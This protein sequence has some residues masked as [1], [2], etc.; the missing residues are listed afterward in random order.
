M[1]AMKKAI[2]IVSHGS[3]DESA[4]REFKHLVHQYQK[5]HSSWRITYAFLELARPSIPEAL[6]KLSRKSKI[7]TVLLLFLFEAKHVKKH[8]PEILTQ[9]RKSRPN[10]TLRL[11]KPLGPDPLLLTILD[12]RLQALSREKKIGTRG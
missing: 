12:Q 1:M 5:R 3:R 2:L 10:V 11:A 6:E 8:I 4:I 9:F 7:I